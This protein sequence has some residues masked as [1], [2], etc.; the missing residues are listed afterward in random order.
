[1]RLSIIVTILG[2]AVWTPAIATRY[3]VNVAATGAGTGLT[4]TNAFTDIQEALSI[5]IP[6]DEIWVAAGQ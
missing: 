5:A 1:M 3:H 6:G 2:L 4:W